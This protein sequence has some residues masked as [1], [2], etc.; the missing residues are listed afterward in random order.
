[1][2][3]CFKNHDSL[4]INST[5]FDNKC[6]FLCS[7]T[8]KIALLKQQYLN[9]KYKQLHLCFMN[10]KQSQLQD[11]DIL[12]VDN[13]E[14]TIDAHVD[15]Q[16]L[17]VQNCRFSYIRGM[18]DSLT[19]LTINGCKLSSIQFL[20]NFR[21][22]RKLVLFTNAITDVSV[23]SN[24]SQL[25]HLDLSSNAIIDF[26]PLQALQ[27]IKELY[28]NSNKIKNIHFLSFMQNLVTVHLINNKITDLNQFAILTKSK[29]LRYLNADE[30]PF[31]TSES[32]RKLEK[33]IH[34]K[35]NP[36]YEQYFPFSACFLNIE[37]SQTK[38]KSILKT[39][40]KNKGAELK[41]KVQKRKQI[42]VNAFMMKKMAL[43]YARFKS[44]TGFE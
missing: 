38:N 9:N 7:N 18:S 33:F 36:A 10:A 43:F 11:F 15:L 6:L 16:Q 37:N 32:K 21:N 25:E 4:S 3:N 27:N 40:C 42:I 1:M 22:L 35:M 23:V 20:V 39:L 26:K 28:L 24:L 19:E 17:S 29:S 34:G 44:F 2:Y 30:N 14:Y 31:L 41:L 13:G 12:N 8:K 5:I